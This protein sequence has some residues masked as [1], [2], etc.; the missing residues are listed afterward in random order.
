MARVPVPPFAGNDPAKLSQRARVECPKPGP[1]TLVLVGLGQSNAGNWGEL[2]ASTQKN[3]DSVIEYWQGNCYAATSPMLGATGEGESL[4]PVLGKTLVQTGYAKQV[5]ISVFAV[6]GA[7]IG[8]FVSKGDLRPLWRAQLARLLDKY[9]VDYY[10]WLQG[11]ADFARGTSKDE[12]AERFS[13][14]RKDIEELD[15]DALVFVS[16]ETYC[17]DIERWTPGNDVARAQSEI[18]KAFPGTLPGVNSDAVLA[19]QGARWDG[20]HPSA[21]GYRIWSEAWNNRI[22]HEMSKHTSSQSIPS[23]VLK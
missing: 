22:V 19:F 2:T 1:G 17:S 6:D 18:S 12:Y 5:L 10:L 8:R 16:I 4:W 3:G 21:Q 20:C 11:E 9:P 23:K 13:K 14:L 7:S 15:G